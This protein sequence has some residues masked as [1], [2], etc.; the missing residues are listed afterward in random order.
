MTVDPA[1]GSIFNRWQG[2]NFGPVLTTQKY[3]TRRVDQITG[4]VLSEADVVFNPQLATR[5]WN[6]L[7]VLQR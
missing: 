5:A 6:T 2:V 1:G 7:R 3:R 4:K